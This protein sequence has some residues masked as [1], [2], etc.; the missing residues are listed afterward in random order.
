MLKFNVILTKSIFF[1]GMGNVWDLTK[2]K[3][4]KEE[5]KETKDEIE[6]HYTCTAKLTNKTSQSTQKQNRWKLLYCFTS[7]STILTWKDF[8]TSTI[9]KKY[10]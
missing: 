2:I 3:K 1:M 7:E 8:K 5:E 6:P 10:P 9:V 4:K